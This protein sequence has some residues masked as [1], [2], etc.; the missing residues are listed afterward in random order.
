MMKKTKK[1]TCAIGIITW[2]DWDK[3]WALIEKLES[4]GSTKKNAAWIKRYNNPRNIGIRRRG[5][6]GL[7]TRAVILLKAA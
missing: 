5:V 2:D 4:L 3:R 1:K 6:L 7:D